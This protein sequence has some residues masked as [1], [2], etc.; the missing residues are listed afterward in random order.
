MEQYL[1][2]SNEHKAW[3]RPK[4]CGYTHDVRAAGRYTLEDAREI[5]GTARSG[6]TDPKKLPDEIPVPLDALPGAIFAAMMA[7]DPERV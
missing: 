1:V 3:W 5:C 2:W 6:W 4:R 7:V